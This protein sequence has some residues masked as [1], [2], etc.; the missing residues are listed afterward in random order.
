MKIYAI[1]HG[2]TAMNKARLINGHLDEPL[3]E[4]GIEQAENARSILPKTLKKIYC[5][6]LLRAKQTAEILNED[7]NLP[8]TYNDGLM[9]VFFGDLEGSDYGIEIQ[10]KHK[11]VVYDWHN[12]GGEDVFDVKKRLLVTLKK[13]N[14]ENLDSEALLVTHGGIIRMLYFLEKGKPQRN[15]DNLSLHVFELDKILK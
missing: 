15:I 2:L 4:E 14:E 1:R 9:E 5:S 10:E 13:I 6:P 3:A 8:I 7:L 11:E 12:V